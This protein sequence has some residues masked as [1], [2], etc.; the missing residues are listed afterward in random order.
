MKVALTGATGFI[1]SRVAKLLRARGDDV[2]CVV[3][4]GVANRSITLPTWL[5]RINAF[6][7]SFVEI[8]VPLPELLSS[9]LARTMGGV[10]Q[11]M[12]RSRAQQELGFEPRKLDA[13]ITEIVRDDLTRLGRPLPPQ[14]SRPST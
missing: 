1:G 6:F 4:T 9:E 5:L 14:L 12:D 13:M 11:N 3:R 2:V 8:V 10:F 7:T